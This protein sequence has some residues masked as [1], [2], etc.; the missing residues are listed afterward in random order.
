MH[1]REE[2]REKL[3]EYSKC[4]RE[5]NSDKEKARST[6]WQVENPEKARAND[7]RYRENHRAERYASSKYWKETHRAQWNQYVL[8]RKRKMGIITK[9]T[10]AVVYDYYGPNCVYCGELAGGGVDHLQPV[11]K[12]GTNDIYNLAPCCSTCNSRKHVRP[13]WEMLP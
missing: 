13:M 9:Q 10:L 8:A 6:R 7:K 11:A 5:K 4:Y 3:R 12:G 1:Y 2:N